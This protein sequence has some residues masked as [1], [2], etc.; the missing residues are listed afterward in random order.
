M[1]NIKVKQARDENDADAGAEFV[2]AHWKLCQLSAALFLWGVLWARSRSTAS[3]ACKARLRPGRET[4]RGDRVPRVG[5]HASVG[6]HNDLGLSRTLR[7]PMMQIC[8]VLLSMVAPS[9]C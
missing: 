9:A 2:I 6:G 4:T 3:R 7:P 5:V 8:Q 1:Y